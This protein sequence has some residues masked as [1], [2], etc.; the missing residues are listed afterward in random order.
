MATP[1][2]ACLIQRNILLPR[3][4]RTRTLQFPFQGHIIQLKIRNSSRELE[5]AEPSLGK[6]EHLK[7]KPTPLPHA[8]A[9]S[10]TF[11]S[12]VHKFIWMRKD[13]S[14]V[15]LCPKSFI[16]QAKGASCAILCV[17]HGVKDPFQRKQT[18][19]VMFQ[20]KRDKECLSY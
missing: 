9:S 18:T 10:A 19:C 13:T 1:N 5:T 11:S 14:R 3:N 6:Q 20:G 7:T 2:T 16:L 15:Q 12:L 4:S 17:Q 8:R